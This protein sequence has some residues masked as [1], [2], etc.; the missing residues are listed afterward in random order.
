M[1]KLPQTVDGNQYILVATEYITKYV[2]VCP[3]FDQATETVARAIV[4]NILLK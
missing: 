1:G 3:M 2:V 4:E